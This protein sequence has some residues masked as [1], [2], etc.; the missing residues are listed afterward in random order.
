MGDDDFGPM[1][2]VEVL[3]EKEACY[4][5]RIS[6]ST[7]RRLVEAGKLSR[8]GVSRGRRLFWIGEIRRLAATPLETVSRRM[9]AA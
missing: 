5:L 2:P 9:E 7:I 8:S 4:T 3:T 1:I 6:K